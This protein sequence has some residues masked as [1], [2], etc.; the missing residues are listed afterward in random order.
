MAIEVESKSKKGKN[1]IVSYTLYIGVALLLIMAASYAFLFFSVQRA[2]QK[3]TKLEDQLD[4]QMDDK[5]KEIEKRILNAQRTL[6]RSE[7]VIN[8][9][10]S[11]YNFLKDL[12][13]STHPQVQFNEMNL[14]A[15]LKQAELSGTTEQFVTLGQQ[16][17]KYQAMK[18][19]NNVQVKRTSMEPGGKVGF[20][21]LLTLKSNIFKFP[22]K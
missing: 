1:K 4:S 21:L 22:P 11:V 15:D 2:D 9:H 16:V 20:E 6:E 13:S 12:E 5:H 19:I 10:H 14:S 7:Q 8:S 18:L 3:L 17:K